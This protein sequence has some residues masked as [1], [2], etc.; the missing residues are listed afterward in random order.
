MMTDAEVVEDLMSR[1]DSE[2]TGDVRERLKTILTNYSS[3][4]SKG[5]YDLGWTDI[6]SHRIDTGDHRPVR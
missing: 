6:V 3:V 1:V 2:V 5:E 4:F